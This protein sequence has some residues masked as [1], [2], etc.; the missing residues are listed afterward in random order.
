[1]IRLEQGH[2]F[3]IIESQMVTFCSRHR[4]NGANYVFVNEVVKQKKRPFFLRT[5]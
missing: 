2:L 5:L 3:L 1:M 4:R